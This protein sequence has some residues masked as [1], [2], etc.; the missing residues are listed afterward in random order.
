MLLGGG[1]TD[2]ATLK[3]CAKLQIPVVQC[4][5]MTETCSQIVALRAQDALRKLGSVG[6]PLF[7]N[8]IRL[9]PENNEILL[10]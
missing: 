9:A 3:Q 7:M 1:T 8:Q 6:Q 4:Y 2:M 10:K 5:G